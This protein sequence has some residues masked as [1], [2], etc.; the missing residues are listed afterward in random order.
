MMVDVRG[1]ALEME[2]VRGIAL[3]ME[4]IRVIALVTVTVHYD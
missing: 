1:I 2:V 4:F 3:E